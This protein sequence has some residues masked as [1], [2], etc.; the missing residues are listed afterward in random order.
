MLVGVHQEDMTAGR[1]VS[2][3][4]GIGG[5]TPFPVLGTYISPPIPKPEAISR[6]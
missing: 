5:P 1:P 6:T 3:T 2:W 4:W